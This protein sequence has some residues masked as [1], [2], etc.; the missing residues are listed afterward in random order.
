[1]KFMTVAGTYYE[2]K[3]VTDKQYRIFYCKEEEVFGKE[4]KKKRTINLK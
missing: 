3:K 1:M 4:N 2:V